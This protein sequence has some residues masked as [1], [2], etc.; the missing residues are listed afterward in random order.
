MCRVFPVTRPAF[1]QRPDLAGRATATLDDTV[2]R[3]GLGG[4]SLHRPVVVAVRGD[5]GHQVGE[6]CLV[7]LGAG[8]QKDDAVERATIGLLGGACDR[9]EA[10]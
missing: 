6:E 1:L 5:G 7:R 8:F 10:S 4:H 9:S 2:G 3:T